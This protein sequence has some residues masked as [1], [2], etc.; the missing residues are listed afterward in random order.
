[1]Q[2]VSCFN[3]CEEK[4][5]N[6]LI[7]NTNSKHLELYSI[8]AEYD[9]AGFPMTYC[10]L[11]T[12]SAIEDQ[13]RTKSLAA[14]ALCVKEHYGVEATFVHVDK[15]MA[16]IAMAKKIWPKAKI[17]LC[18]WHLRRA[19]RTRLANGKLSTTPYNMKRAHAEF[20]FID[21]TFIPVGRPDVSEFE[22]GM[23]DDLAAT[24]EPANQVY[25]EKPT[26]QST[27]PSSHT[28][29]SSLSSQDTPAGVGS[30]TDIAM[31]RITI[32]PRPP[33]PP[34]TPKRIDLSAVLK[35]KRSGGRR[36]VMIRLVEPRK[37][38]SNGQLNGVTKETVS[39]TEDEGEPARRTFCP[40]IHH[41]K[42]LTML[43]N[44]YCAHPLIPGYGPP[45]A[46]GIRKW[47]VRRMYSYCKNN[48]LPEVWAY[49]WENW[50]RTG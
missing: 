15:D 43:E 31:P 4:N 26:Y 41:E 23:H 25:V 27:P 46:E 24:Y 35:T 40:K 2:H 14:W 13:K 34:Q 37:P 1:M 6:I 3:I 32:P 11:S 28:I 9:N 50:Y 19:V 29:A 45:S 30:K 18:W 36:K 20:P 39:E 7:D 8:M 12:A 10:L 48:K 47:A 17:S 42:I 49:L 22:G 44:H 16:E 38:D 21:P 33:P 5:V